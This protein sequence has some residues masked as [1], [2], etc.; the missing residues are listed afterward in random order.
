M[1]YDPDIWTGVLEKATEKGILGLEDVDI[2]AGGMGEALAKFGAAFMG[3]VPGIAIGKKAG[4]F[5]FKKKGPEIPEFKTK[6][7]LPREEITP[8]AETE[9]GSYRERASKIAKDLKGREYSNEDIQKVLDS[10]A[11]SYGEVSINV[12][13]LLRY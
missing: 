7:V 8:G 10:L 11:S 2:K 12:E 6:V 3:I 4:W 5:P 1:R 13:E 9:T